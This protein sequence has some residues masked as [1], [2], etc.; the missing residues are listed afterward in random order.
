MLCS[1]ELT[2]AGDSF[3]TCGSVIFGRLL[4]FVW[5]SVKSGLNNSIWSTGL[6]QWRLRCE[7]QPGFRSTTEA[8]TERGLMWRWLVLTLPVAVGFVALTGNAPL[9]GAAPMSQV[10][11]VT[12]TTG[13]RTVTA[14][15]ATGSTTTVTVP[16]IV[17]T[18]QPSTVTSTV[19]ATVTTTIPA[20]ASSTATETITNTLTTTIPVTVTTGTTTTTTTSTVLDD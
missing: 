17:T 10:V 5:Q 6:S 1:S 12:A 13:T 2:I 16:V 14:Q 9:V 7:R 8:M 15:V 20:T 3:H 18:G 4:I 11:T 19:S